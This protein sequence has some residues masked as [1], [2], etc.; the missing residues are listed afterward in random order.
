MTDQCHSVV[1]LVLYS[2]QPGRLCYRYFECGQLRAFQAAVLLLDA[3]GK[4]AEAGKLNFLITAQ[5]TAFSRRIAK[6]RRSCGQGNNVQRASDARAAHWR[7]S[8]APRRRRA[9]IACKSDEPSRHGPSP[10]LRPF[11]HI[12][13]TLATRCSVPTKKGPTNLDNSVSLRSLAFIGSWPHCRGWE[14]RQCAI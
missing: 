8:E 14:H 5:A 10:A 7:R 4:T 9:V 3:A 1:D 6:K 11:R 13:G 12:R 2:S